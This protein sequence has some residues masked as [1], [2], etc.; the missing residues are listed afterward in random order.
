MVDSVSNGLLQAQIYNTR[1]SAQL[2][3]V[4]SPQEAQKKAD[5]LRQQTMAA[6][7]ALPAKN[8]LRENGGIQAVLQA[9]ES[10]PNQNLPRG[11]LLD[12]LV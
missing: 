3:N 6:Q 11:T 2:Q 12:I 4:P 10:S 7:T 5:A 8:L 1:A 9:A